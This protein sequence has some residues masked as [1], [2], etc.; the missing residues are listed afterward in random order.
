M[1]DKNYRTI[2]IDRAGAVAA[3]WLDRPQ[4]KNA[5]NEELIAELTEACTHLSQ[6]KETRVVTLSGKGDVF[7]AGADLNWMRRVAAYTYEENLCDAKRFAAMLEGLY[8]LPQATIAAVNGPCIGG[9]VGLLSACDVAVAS[10]KAFFVLAE[11]RL[12]IAPAVISP[13]V[14]RKIEERKAREYFL[15]GRRFDA[16]T[17]REIG[18]V[19][20][21]VSEELFEESVEK[22]VKRF[23]KAAPGAIKVCKELIA[24]VARAPLGEVLDYTAETIANL[25]MAP[26]GREGFAA[27]FEKRKPNWDPDS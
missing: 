19:N 14:I 21:V 25:R 23:T 7:S 17:A 8:R 1:S 13:Y 20:D 12:G 9:G 27:F 2:A 18:L 16:Q 11:I 26:E 6:D 22:W 5:F 3:I 24:H 10:E 4:V 15:S